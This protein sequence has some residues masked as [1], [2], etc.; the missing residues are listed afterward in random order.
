MENDRKS[1]RLLII[2]NPNGDTE[3]KLKWGPDSQQ[4]EDMKSQLN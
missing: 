2:R 1:H 3:W 4:I